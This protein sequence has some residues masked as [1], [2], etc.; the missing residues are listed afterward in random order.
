[1]KAMLYF[2]AFTVRPRS[3]PSSPRHVYLVR[4]MQGLPGSSPSDLMG[5]SPRPEH[6]DRLLEA[7]DVVL[8]ERLRIA[9]EEVH[10]GLRHQ[11]R[12]AE[13]LVELRD[14]AR[15]VNV[16]ADHREIEALARSD[17][18]V[19]RLAVVEGDADVDQDRKAALEIGGF[20]AR[21][22]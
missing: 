8:A 6:R 22:R 15:K 21:Q 10:E 14:P 13:L 4:W 20:D 9:P 18:A 1:M 5:A 11:Q 7:V 12:L 2:R 3:Q 19:R 16:P 17:V